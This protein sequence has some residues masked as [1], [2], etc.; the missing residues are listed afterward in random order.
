TLYGKLQEIDKRRAAI[1]KSIEEQ[2]KLTDELRTS[3]EA[4]DSLQELEDLYL[5][6]RPKRK[7]RASA[8]RDKGLEP[9]A[10]QLMAPGCSA[11]PETL[12][13]KFLSD[14]VPDTASALQGA[15]DIMAEWISDSRRS[16]QTVRR[17]FDRQ[18]IIRSAVIKGK[19]QDGIVYQHYFDF[20]EPLR[21]SPSHRILAMLRGERE[22]ILK[23]TIA[24]A[25]QDAVQEALIRNY[26]TQPTS[27]AGQ[28]EMAVRDSCNRL[29]LPAMETEYKQ[30]AKERADTDAI[31][32]FA[33]NLRQ[34]LLA[35]P[36]GEKAVLAIDPG[37][38][39]GCKVVCLDPQGNLM[40]NETIFPHPP[41]SEVVQATRK[42]TSLVSAYKI[43]AIAIGNGTA[44]RETER[45]IQRLIFGRDV[46]VFSV[47]ESGAS[48]Y[49]ASAVAREEFPDYDVT[50]RG[51]VSIGRRLM[52]PL[53]ELVK[54]D[55]KSIG[56]GQYQHDVDQ[57]LLKASLDTVVESC[58][59]HVGVNVNTAGRHLLTYVSG[60]GPQLAQ[61]IV[62]YRTEHGPFSSREELKSVPRM[63][64]RTFE[65]CAG[66][67]R[68]PDADNP[69]D[70]SAVHPESYAIVNRMAEDLHTDV[71]TLLKDRKLQQQIDLN[72]YV[73]S[74]QDGK[75]RNDKT[76]GLVATEHQVGLPTLQ[77]IMQELA[78]PGRDPRS[79]IDVFEFSQDVHQI[80]D[81]QPGMILPG[82][83]TNITDFGCFVDIGV[84]QD[85]LVHVSQLAGRYVKHPSEVVKVYDHVQ[86]KVLDV[87]VARK[88]ISLSMKNLGN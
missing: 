24:A 36:L 42:I 23:V 28:I 2:G 61:R 70:N 79:R 78:K 38:R 66:F 19:A 82:I 18:A 80:E 44:G 85:G 13:G 50:V 33:D 83:V 74:S 45:F 6:F 59:N 34:L 20:Q 37:F 41:Q 86:V 3:L 65:Q 39:T 55:P 63:G 51:A 11:D 68:I 21:K 64:S 35:P 48:V 56:V 54:I 25:T 14:A 88:R 46:Q 69:L 12:A 52:D 47:N 71:R 1:L 26:V 67:L 16:R 43:D 57:G 87:D 27:A 77:D 5:P 58:V 29:L 75:A 17:I 62:D 10:R 8:A 84:K 40:H 81:V 53:S 73:T 22:G 32:I 9:L 30:R 60:V 15:R 76:E 72:R 7:T 49:S 31:R 4:T